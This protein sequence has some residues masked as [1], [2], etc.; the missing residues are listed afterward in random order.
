MK[1]MNKNLGIQRHLEKII[2]GTVVEWLECRDC[3][4]HAV[5]G[6]QKGVPGARKARGPLFSVLKKG[7]RSHF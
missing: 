3:D 1:K 7:S 6:L 4:R 2:V 5:M